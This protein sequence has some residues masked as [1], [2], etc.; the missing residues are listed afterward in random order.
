MLFNVFEAMNASTVMTQGIARNE[1]PRFYSRQWIDDA[2]RS[3][4]EASTQPEAP[5]L[6]WVTDSLTCRFAIGRGISMRVIW[7]CGDS[8]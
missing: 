1:D 6:N 8:R 4:L 3:A 5:D 2:I 7:E